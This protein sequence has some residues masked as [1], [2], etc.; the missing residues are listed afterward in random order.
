MKS[1]KRRQK[2]L[3]SLIVL[4]ILSITLFI[5]NENEG[6]ILEQTNNLSFGNLTQTQITEYS[7]TET[8]EYQCTLNMPEERTVILRIDD[9][10]PWNNLNL[11]EAMTR[12]I[13]DRDYGASLGIIP[14]RMEED[15][16]LI[17]WLQE[18]NQNE[19]VELSQHGHEHSFE[20]FG[21]LNYEQALEKIELGKEIMM[22]YF[23]EIPLNFIPP[24][25]LASNE[26]IDALKD[27]GFKTYSGGT[28]DK[29]VEENFIREGYDATT[30]KYFTEE[31]IYAE[32][33]LE[34]CN[35]SLDEKGICVI[36][37]HPQDFT[38]D[39]KIVDWK[40]Q[41][42]IKVLEG[43]EGLDAQV[44]SFREGFCREFT[45]QTLQ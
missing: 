12:E 14:K 24:Y 19:K 9:I 17:I 7:L 34:D 3:V 6:Y 31:F 21:N 42:F 40:Y 35:N 32:E 43:L 37:F 5:F 20:E 10:T 29:L 28:R 1:E 25:N 27:S 11:M 22:K 44:V 16:E 13:I 45:S 8:T 2:I 36:M 33:V 30:Y 18:I 23:G 4:G 26:T 38:E 41:E 39:G 15:R